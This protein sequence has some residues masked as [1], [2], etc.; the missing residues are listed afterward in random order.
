MLQVKP[1]AK[2]Y[3]AAGTIEGAFGG[4]KWRLLDAVRR[5]G[6]IQRAAESLGRSYRKAWGDIRRA[7]EGLGRRLVV[8]SRG[9]PGGGR[10]VLTEFGIKLLAAWD[11]YHSSVIEGVHRSYQEHLAPVIGPED[12]SRPVRRRSR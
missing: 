3:L 11:Q 6:S 9:G 2:L 1:Q 12:V 10:T 4:G 7:E 8:R 5:E